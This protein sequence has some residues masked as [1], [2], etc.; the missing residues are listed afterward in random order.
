V[1]SIEQV[2]AGLSAAAG[3]GQGTVAQAQAAK[4]GADRM[5][6]QLRALAQGTSHPKIQ[7][8]IAKAEQARQK[9]DEASALAAAAAESARAYVAILG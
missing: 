8:A 5:I 9:L 2:K 3:E 6:S 1:T 4:A 7:E